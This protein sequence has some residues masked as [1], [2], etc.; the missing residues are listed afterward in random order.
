[1]L[2][3]MA[4]G[5]KAII[6]IWIYKTN[7][8]TPASNGRLQRPGAGKQA[9]PLQYAALQLLRMTTRSSEAKLEAVF[10]VRYKFQQASATARPERGVEKPVRA[11][12]E[13]ADTLLL[14]ATAHRRRNA[15]RFCSEI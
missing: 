13:S 3:L 11:H 7:C 2:K 1:M 4:N 6:F 14:L 5:L 9:K 10:A 15:K 8:H 12:D